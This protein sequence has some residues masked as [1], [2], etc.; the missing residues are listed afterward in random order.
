MELGYRNIV[1]GLEGCGKSSSI[2]ELLKDSVT[3]DSPILFGVK[4]YN[5]MEEQI[6]NWSERYQVDKDNFAICGYSTNY[7]RAKE[8]YTN[9]E[10]PYLLG[11]NTRFVFSTQAQ[12]Q[13]NHH[14]KFKNQ[15]GQDVI[16]SH[17][18]IDEFD[19]VNGIIP[20]LDFYFSR[21]KDLEETRELELQKYNWI[22]KN[23]TLDDVSTL[24]FKQKIHC[25]GFTVAFWVKDTKC[26]LTFL[27]SE[28]LSKDLLLSLP[29]N[30]LLSERFKEIKVESP[31]FTD[32][33]IHTFSYDFVNKHFFEQFNK[34][35]VWD[36][37]E[38]DYIISDNLLS[39]YE[40]NSE[41]YSLT[42]EKCVVPHMGARG[43]NLFRDSK[44]LTVLSHIPNRKIKEVF[45]TF[46]YF[47]KEKSYEEIE[48]LFYR[49]RLCQAVGRVLGNRGS[50]ETHLIV[51][52]Q[53][54][55]TISKGDFPYT[56]KTD[57]ELDFKDSTEVFKAIEESAR[58]DNDLRKEARTN[59]QAISFSILEN[60][61]EYEEGSL[62]TV[63]DFKEFA[64]ENKLKG[65]SLKS[66][67]FISA[68][69]VANYFKQKYSLNNVEVKNVRVK[70]LNRTC[71]C[72]L[73][74]K[75]K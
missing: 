50:K 29:E 11:P 7:E 13:K 30:E 43:S 46:K 17:I 1:S 9:K 3:V 15:Q 20:T 75:F 41:R 59:Y 31:D 6:N 22:L 65:L 32:C 38:F 19:F 51:H 5:L 12:I 14:K 37:L 42:L 8:A 40:K 61:F 27:T 74:L 24:Q 54:L 18:I 35:Q 72:I 64:K 10:M 34:A 4:N 21:I 25:E 69:K 58:N 60:Y 28:L 2:F 66:K 73:G 26:P 48:R 44:V 36:S 56:F 52:S 33:V 53:L 68:T 49:D 45:E 67:N 62:I 16:W 47:E 39:W 63:K 71:S 70:E 23:Y 55:N 57:W